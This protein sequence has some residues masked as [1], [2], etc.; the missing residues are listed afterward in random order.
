MPGGKISEYDPYVGPVDLVNDLVDLTQW[1]GGP[2]Y[3]TGGSRKIPVEDLLDLAPNLYTS[4]GML[5]DPVRNAALNLGELFFQ[6]GYVSINE[7]SSG[8]CLN[9]AQNFAT[10]VI[11]G[12][13]MTTGTV[14][15]EIDQD[16]N[17]IWEGVAGI[18]SGINSFHRLRLDSIDL[19]GGKGLFVQGA[20]S[21]PNCVG[22]DVEMTTT[23]N[24]NLW[25]FQANITNNGFGGTPIGG[26]FQAN[27]SAAYFAYGVDGVATGGVPTG[28]RFRSI[29]SGQRGY[30]IELEATGGSV[31][32]IAI[33]SIL[34]KWQN[35]DMP[36]FDDDAAAGLGGMTT[37]QI[38][39]A[40]GAGAEGQGVL[41]IKQ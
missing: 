21:N 17:H 35:N 32:D 5:T 22:A 6:R 18:G 38:Y 26:Q 34:G 33:L 4:D 23:V 36:A 30:A 27:N 8:R 39:Q 31:E 11:A 28:G 25:G 9:V 40:T 3:P 29:S 7:G 1:L 19:N 24:N 15:Y 20:I 2:N 12:F 37:G 41:M 13:K 14:A 16:G 10:D